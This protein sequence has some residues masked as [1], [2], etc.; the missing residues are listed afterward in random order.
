VADV[1]AEGS[2]VCMSKMGEKKTDQEGTGFLI[3]L[4]R[5]NE[6][7]AENAAPILRGSGRRDQYIDAP[8]HGTAFRRRIGRQGSIW[9]VTDRPNPV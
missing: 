4:L 5:F 2:H 7:P 3:G 8:V 6:L 1:L 9:P